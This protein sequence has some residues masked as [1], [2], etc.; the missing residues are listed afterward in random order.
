MAGCPGPAGRARAAEVQY[1]CP[2]RYLIVLFFIYTA[3]NVCA[4]FVALLL[5]V[6]LC[7]DLQVE[8]IGS[9]VKF[10]GG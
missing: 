10:L 6:H 2:G 1:L 9:C 7:L 8:S 5:S 3:S 4:H